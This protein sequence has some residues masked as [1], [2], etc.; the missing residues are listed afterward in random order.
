MSGKEIIN[1]MDQV[2]Q[3]I[4]N[5]DKKIKELEEK[6][7][8]LDEV[9]SIYGEENNNWEDEENFLDACRDRERVFEK[10]HEGTLV[11]QG[12]VEL[13]ESSGGDE[14]IQRYYGLSMLRKY[15]EKTFG[16]SFHFDLEDGKFN[17][18]ITHPFNEQIDKLKEEIK[19]LQEENEELNKKKSIK[20]SRDFACPLIEKLREENKYLRE[21]IKKMS[22]NLCVP[23]SI[24]ET[25]VVKDQIDPHLLIGNADECYEK[26]EGK[27]REIID[28]D[29][30]N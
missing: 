28:E 2:I 8:L 19:E 11:E 21:T 25:W 14:M 7:E 1:G 13:Q 16:R 15:L 3:Y 10:F 24:I 30:H 29:P 26:V 17:F 23:Q 12:E 9:K 4:Q 22:F 6:V 18:D 5:Q 27:W 20:W